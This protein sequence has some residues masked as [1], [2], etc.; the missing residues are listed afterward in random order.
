VILGASPDKPAKQAKFRRKYGLPFTLLADEQH[1]LADA[2]GVWKLKNF[3]G[4]SYYGI[5]RSTA[6]I[7]PKGKVA[8]VFEKVSAAGHAEAVGRALEELQAG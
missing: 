2:W 3:M 5:E 1:T 6:I 7:D 4:K 8:R